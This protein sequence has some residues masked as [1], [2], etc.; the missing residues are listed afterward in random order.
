MLARSRSLLSPRLLT[1]APITPQ[2]ALR[3]LHSTL[4]TQDGLT[5]LFESDDQPALS[6]TKLNEKGFVLTD[7]LVIPGGMIFL[8]NRPILWDVNPPRMDGVKGV[9][10][11]WKG[12]GKEAFGVLELVVPRPGAFSSFSSPLNTRFPGLTMT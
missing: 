12:F 2:Y 10:E 4:R 6:I 5:N 3:P 9:E 11:A 7:N 1:S 8:D